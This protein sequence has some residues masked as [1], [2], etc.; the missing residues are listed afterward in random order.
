MS[1]KENEDAFRDD[2]IRGFA[3]V[4]WLAIRIEHRFTPGVSDLSYCAP[5]GPRGWIELKSSHDF[6]LSKPLSQLDRFTELQ[7][8]FLI[9]QGR[10]AGYAFLAVRYWTSDHLGVRYI[11]Y[12]FPWAGLVDERAPAMNCGFRV[13]AQTPNNE[14]LRDVF[15]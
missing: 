1:R 14:H 11:D 8:R 3:N 6:D 9:K 2:M 15:A 13:L 12:V 5:T 4:G 10:K 7:R